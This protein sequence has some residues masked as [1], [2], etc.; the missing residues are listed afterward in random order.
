M[1]WHGVPV[2]S[3]A[4][5]GVVLR[6]DPDQLWRVIAIASSRDLRQSF[7]ATA[8]VMVSPVQVVTA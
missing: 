2:R 6:V 4:G 5:T 8:A 1:L 3:G 7:L